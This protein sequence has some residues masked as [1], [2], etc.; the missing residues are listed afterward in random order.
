[1]LAQ[2][3]ATRDRILDRE[4]MKLLH[5]ASSNTLVAVGTTHTELAQLQR[6]LGLDRLAIANGDPMAVV[7]ETGDRLE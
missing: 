6:S 1:M 3:G 2:P 7:F 5:D 4:T